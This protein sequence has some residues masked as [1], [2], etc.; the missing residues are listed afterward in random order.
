MHKKQLLIVLAI[1]ILLIFSQSSFAE[2]VHSWE[3]VE[4]E[5]ESSGLLEN[6]YVEGLPDDGPAYLSV[7]FKGIDKKAKGQQLKLRG[8]WDGGKTWKVRFAAPAEG[9]WTYN[10]TSPD[11]AMDGKTGEL[12][13]LPWNDQEKNDNPT[14]HGFVCVN[15]NGEQPGHYFMYADETP[16]LWI[17]DTWWNW[18]K[19]GIPFHRFKTLADD[20]AEKGFTIGQLFFAGRGWG[21]SSSLLDK[22]YTKPDIE[23]IHHIEKYIRY[24]NEKGITV[25]IHGWWSI[26]KL[27]E[28]IGAEPM[29]RWWRYMVHRLGAYNVIWVLAGEYNMHNYGGMGL[30]FWKNLGKLIKREDPYNRIISTHPTPP[31]WRGGA[32][33]PQ[34]STHEIL[35]NEP[36]L[37]YNQSQTGHGR[38]R[39]EMIPLIVT[40]A[41]N[42]WPPKPIVVTEPWYEFVQGNPTARD[43]RFGTWSAVLSGAAGHSYAGGHVWKAHVPEAP[44]G[45]DTWPMEMEF[46]VN[47]LDYPGA[48]SVGF[49]ATF[50]KNVPFWT[51]EPRP[52]LIKGNPSKYCG[53]MQDPQYL[54]YLR[55]GGSLSIKL[56]GSSPTDT[57]EYR[58]YNLETNDVSKSGQVQGAQKAILHPPASY[59][60]I[61]QFK[62][63][64]LHIYPANKSQKDNIK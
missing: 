24:A 62:D 5:F 19:R 10:S 49:M 56:E 18:T 29:R 26:Q 54:I 41:R 7:T 61:K 38:W 50:L 36:W 11:P 45:N 13:V 16:F 20:R 58:W 60:G 12:N 25:W 55:Y 52:D 47:T 51:M 48:Q 44:A 2:T 40:E 21:R 37:D 35:H 23:H 39:N 42:L 15:Q 3:P 1:I 63:W 17:G 46:D 4:I 6:P 22:T 34:W 32:D 27:D 9:T 33:A 28:T 64:L 31:Y 8:F 53:M 30:D 57:F 14:R 43:I 59:P